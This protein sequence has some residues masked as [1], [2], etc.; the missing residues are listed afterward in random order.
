M[1]PRDVCRGHW[2]SGRV[3]RPLFFCRPSLGGSLGEGL[4]RGHETIAA[5][6][7]Y[8]RARRRATL[9]HSDLLGQFR[10]R[11]IRSVSGS[12]DGVCGGRGRKEGCG[13]EE[14]VGLPL[15][16]LLQTNCRYFFGLV[17]RSPVLSSYFFL[18]PLH[19]ALS[20][21]PI[22]IQLA[23]RGSWWAAR[24]FWNVCLS[25]PPIPAHYVMPLDERKLFTNSSSALQQFNRL[26]TVHHITKGRL[27]N[28][29]SAN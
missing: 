28:L 17:F 2:G 5:V 3:P 16:G 10:E 18:M 1:R 29:Y 27:L 14:A 21:P 22:K 11:R 6:K 8:G 4:L 13:Q 19:P 20:L 15:G 9:R 26:A 25:S 7:K 23:R 24:L 12:V